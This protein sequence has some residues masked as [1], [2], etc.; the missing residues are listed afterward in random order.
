M[1]YDL[2]SNHIPRIQLL[3]EEGR[4]WKEVVEWFH[5]AGI[6]FTV[7]AAQAAWFKHQRRQ[8]RLRMA[9]IANHNREECNTLS[10]TDREKLLHKAMAMI[11]SSGQTTTWREYYA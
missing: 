2:A 9:E 11:Y 6:D 5:D 8:R 1:S 4:T 7:L 3:R 10:D